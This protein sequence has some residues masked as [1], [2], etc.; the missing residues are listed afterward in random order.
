MNV[1]LAG[2]LGIAFF[3]ATGL[4]LADLVPS[5]ARRPALLRL[6][7]AYLL[8]IG[9]TAG[10][11]YAASHVLGW[12]LRRG[13]ILPI[14]MI[15][16]ALALLLRLTRGIRRRNVDSPRAGDALPLYSPSKK[17]PVSFSS[18]QEFLFSLVFVIPAIVTLAIFVEAA[19][20]PI[21]DWDGRMTW[22]AQ[23]RYV[24]QE[25]TV[26]PTVLTDLKWYAANRE[27][28]LLMPLAQV[29]MQ[30]T[31]STS[32]DER[33]IRPLYAAFFPVLLLLVF[34]G[35][36]RL[37]GRRSAA[38]SV[39]IASAV[40][41]FAFDAHGGAAGC[42]SDL[43]LAC[44][45]GGGVLLLVGRRIALPQAGAAGVL[46]GA[47]VLTKA[48]G[49]LL[50]I[51]AVGIVSL[52][53][54]RRRDPR[55]LAAPALAAAVVLAAAA[56]YVSWRARIPSHFDVT[57]AS[58]LARLDTWTQLLPRMGRAGRLALGEAVKVP[59]WKFFWILP[60]IVAL[61]GFRALRRRAA[62]QLL[63]AAA[64]PVAVAFAAY[65]IFSWELSWF[66]GVTFSRFLV[67]GAV[68]LLCFFA[69]CLR[70]ALRSRPFRGNDRPQFVS[71]AVEHS[72]GSQAP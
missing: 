57:H 20:N 22:T 56:L 14:A 17:S 49:L 67:Q 68:P 60:P 26:L 13:T 39:L 25:R 30:E 44:F 1:A 38:L 34:D 62:W 23:A 61:C 63:L 69:M 18:K 6:A 59:Q 32:D 53:P 28:P 37:A 64:A 33:L 71:V 5:L 55:A 27:Y 7:Y 15:P 2:L 43:P 51:A 10:G 50:A 8:G 19:T 46:L 70:E 24:R 35:A 47:A 36:S 54:L 48:E 40:P 72:G 41:M 3:L 65:G 58:R 42:Y 4:A 12:T 52:R 9:W 66:V 45:F 16:I 29:A 21:D 31:F 11:I